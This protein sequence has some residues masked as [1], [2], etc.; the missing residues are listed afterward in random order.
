M[1]DFRTLQVWH[2]SRPLTLEVYQVTC[3]L[4]REELHGLTTQSSD[5]E[6]LAESATEV[7]RMLTALIFKLK[8]DG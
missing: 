3:G 8:A 7:K 2:K 4:P 6:R 1:R 5:Y